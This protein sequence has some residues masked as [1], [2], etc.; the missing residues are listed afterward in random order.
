MKK[1]APYLVGALVG[2]AALAI[3]QPPRRGGQPGIIKPEMSDTIQANVYADNW[4]AL[5][6]NGKLVAVDPIDFL[7][8]NVVNISI[9]PEY[10]MTVAV[11]AKD[12]ADPK[13]G[14]EYGDYVGDGGFVMKFSDGTVTDAKWKVKTIFSGPPVKNEPI[15]AGWFL[16]SFDDSKWASATEYTNER[17]NPK[18]PYYDYNF[19]G[20]KFIWSRD[21]DLDNTILLRTKIEKPGWKPRWT[22]KPDLDTSSA[23]LR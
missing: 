15:P 23:P 7:P 22:T 19:E 5:Y 2:A 18:K 13:T 11:I 9:L 6:I 1:Y 14:F 12:N 17:V 10:P 20:A 8:H 16:P 3:A 4:F 21:L